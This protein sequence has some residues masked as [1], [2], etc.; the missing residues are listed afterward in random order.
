MR[1]RQLDVDR[2]VARPSCGV[3]SR[4]ALTADLVAH[5]DRVVATL[6]VDRPPHLVLG[7]LCDADRVDALAEHLAARYDIA[8][9]RVVL[10]DED[11]YRVDGPGWVARLFP[12]GTD[13]AVAATADLLR[14]LASTKFPA[15]RL[16]HDQPVSVCGG[17]PVLV[18]EFVEGRQAPGTP[19]MFAAL[20]AWLGGL[21][22]RPGEGLA[23]GGGW[24]HLVPQGT[25]RDEIAAALAL[26]TDADGDP[27]ARQTLLDELRGL[28]DCADLPH[29]IVHPD[30]VPVNVIL[31]P[32]R[33]LVVVDWAGSGRGPRLWSLGFLLWAA[34][35]RDLAL[36][37][38]VVSRYREHTQLTAD[39]I[40]RL[41]GAIRARPLTI[42]CW[43][44]AHS[45][46]GGADAVQRLD[47]REELTEAIA[48]RTRRA[49]GT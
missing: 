38:A 22:A 47:R 5:R 48:D 18:T 14:R 45:R 27:A 20:G 19:R 41:P 40:D 2:R 23:P 25:P 36:V 42:D 8:V 12:P 30:F 10:L 4:P 39:E 26:L 34:G 9:D 29:A 32:E 46:L 15:E 35:A 16:A 31:R 28:D 33:G 44:V 6:V 49:L 13:D 21:H 43:S 7:E 17:R 1:A 3:G 37:D 24:H 11:V